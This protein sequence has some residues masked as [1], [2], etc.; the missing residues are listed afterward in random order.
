MEVTVALM[1]VLIL[2]AAIVVPSAVLDAIAHIPQ[3]QPDRRHRRER[4][5]AVERAPFI[6]LFP[7]H[8]VT[9]LELPGSVAAAPHS[10]QRLDK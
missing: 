5:V 6:Y 2:A 1:V 4:R 9:V 7:A 8:S 10:M 3:H